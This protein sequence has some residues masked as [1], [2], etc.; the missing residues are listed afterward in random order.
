VTAHA[1]SVQQEVRSNDALENSK[2]LLEFSKELLENS[3]GASAGVPSFDVSLHRSATGGNGATGERHNAIHAVIGCVPHQQTV[4]IL[5]MDDPMVNLALGFLRGH[6][7]ADLRFDEH[8]R[9]IRYVIGRKG[10]LASPVMAAMLESADT[11]LFIPEYREEKMLEVQ[12]TLEP[13]REEQTGGEIADRWRIYHGEPQDIYWAMM[14][15]DAAK[16]ADHVVDGDAL[17]VENTLAG[18]E[19]RLCKLMNTEH[20]SDLRLLCHHFAHIEIEQPRMVGIDPLGIDVRGMFDVVRVKA[21]EPF[22][23]A[24]HAH[25]VIRSMIAAAREAMA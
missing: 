13:F 24:E 10:K 4:T 6:T 23:S 3:E 9:P 15:I 17:M 11:V 1:R 7:T 8:L 18:D 22:K 19:P 20:E 5:A 2:R 12:V 16:Y 14:L 21:A 25:E